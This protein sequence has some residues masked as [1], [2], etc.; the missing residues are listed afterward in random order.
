MRHRLAYR[1]GHRYLAGPLDAG[2]LEA[3]HG[4]AVEQGD[5]AAF[6]DAVADFCHFAEA[7]AAPARQRHLE[8]GNVGDR[9]HR[10]QGAYR[11]D[12]VADITATAGSVLLHLPQQARHVSGG[13]AQRRQARGVQVDLHLAVDPADAADFADTLDRQHG[14]GDVVVDEPRQPLLVDALGTHGV[15]EDRAARGGDLGNHRVAHRWRQVGTHRVD[16]VAHFVE[17][18][19]GVLVDVESHLDRRRAVGERGGDVFDA[20]QRGDLILDLARHLG[21]H[22]GRRNTLV[23]GG[24]GDRRQL[25]VREVLDAQ[26]AEAA[27]AE[28]GQQAKKQQR[29]HR[30]ADRPGGEVHLAGSACDAAAGALSTRTASPSLRKAPPLA[31]MR[32]SV[33]RGV[34]IST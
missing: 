16:C 18:H 30:V 25:D 17:R 34:R 31:T 32:A 11:L 3:D 7:D 21:F 4:L 14:L 15:G 27:D 5:A 24:N 20:T 12:A 10:R 2:D 23:G 19:L 28:E 33:G 1:L 26:R 6:G 8:C 29:R 22:L 13:D 9:A